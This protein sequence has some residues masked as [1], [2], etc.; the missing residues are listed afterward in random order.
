MLPA[1]KVMTQEDIKG[2]IRQEMSEICKIGKCGTIT[3]M[4][5]LFFFV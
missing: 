1:R 5:A 3:K 4:E 2:I